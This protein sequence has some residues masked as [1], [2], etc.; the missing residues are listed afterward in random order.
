MNR[1]LVHQLVLFTTAVY[2]TLQIDYEELRLDYNNRSMILD[3]AVYMDLVD[4]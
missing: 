1:F 3:Y 2:K 4:N